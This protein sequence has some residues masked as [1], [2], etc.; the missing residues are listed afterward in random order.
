MVKCYTCKSTISDNSGSFTLRG[1]SR[2]AGC[3]QASIAAISI[4]AQALGVSELHGVYQSDATTGLIKA[5]QAMGA[6]V[7]YVEE[8]VLVEGVG[9]GG[10]AAIDIEPVLCSN[11]M[12]ACTIMGILATNP[13]LSFLISSNGDRTACNRQG[14]T[15]SIADIKAV[16]NILR[17]IGVKF[18]YKRGLPVAIIG[19]E[20]APPI[21]VSDSISHENVKTAV[22][23]ASI[24]IQGDNSIRAKST[25]PNYVEGLLRDFSADIRVERVGSEDVI[26]IGGQKE[27][28]A[29]KT[30]VPPSTSQVLYVVGAV[31]ILCG[32]TVTIPQVYLDRTLESAMNIFRKMGGDASLTRSRDYECTIYVNSSRMIG[33]E[34]GV[35]E[36]IDIADELP[37]ICIVCAC[38]SGVTR[39]FGLASL[40]DSLK[41]R[42]NAVVSGLVECGVTASIMGDVLEIRGCG[43]QVTGGC[44]LDAK[45]DPRVAIPFFLLG[46]ISQRPIAVSGVD[47]EDLNVCVGALN[48]FREKGDLLSCSV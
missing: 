17:A 47:S 26:T 34:I 42:M 27:L 1:V 48:R 43:G 31:L 19:I 10:F 39:I 28:F 25:L 46:M 45:G 4:A 16:E 24:N 41:S 23:M 15:G 13:N 9:V 21:E 18:Q 35:D 40:R 12:C 36:L 32:S 38:S 33:A 44:T 29:C 3:E 2:I 30:Y 22:L 6:K 5:V 20:D 7:T 37:T 8:V 14:D 11:T